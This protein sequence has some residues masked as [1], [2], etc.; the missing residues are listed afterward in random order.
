[1]PVPP[2][3]IR[4]WQPRFL[5]AMASSPLISLAVSLTMA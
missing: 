5:T 4:V 3:R 1:M 2:L